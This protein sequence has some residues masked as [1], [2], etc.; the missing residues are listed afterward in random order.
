MA[1]LEISDLS[2]VGYWQILGKML[3]S[4][5]EFVLEFRC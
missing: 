2:F 5:Y 3:D 1:E 4:K